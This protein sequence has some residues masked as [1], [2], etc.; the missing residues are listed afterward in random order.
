MTSRLMKRRYFDDSRDKQVFIWSGTW[1]DVLNEEHQGQR[2]FL[3]RWSGAKYYIL[4]KTRKQFRT[5]IS[6]YV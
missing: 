2:F 5:T 3:N 6:S 1:H 4:E